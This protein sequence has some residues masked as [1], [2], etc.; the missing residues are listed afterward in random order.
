[1]KNKEMSRSELLEELG[2]LNKKIAELE[3]SEDKYRLISEKGSTLIATA[4]FTTKPVYTYVS[5]SYK[6]VLGSEPQDIVGKP[7]LDFL[8]HEDKERFTQLL[9]KYVDA[10]NTDTLPPDVT[11]TVE[12]RIRDT[13]ARGHWRHIESTVNIMH[14]ELLFISRD[15]TERKRAEELLKNAQAVL[16][17]RVE[18]RT[19]EL[20]E[21]N[22][23]L[24]KQIAERERIE[25]ELRESET[26]YRS[27]IDAMGDAIH[28]IDKDF[29]IVFFNN[30]FAEWTKD[31]NLDIVLD[32]N[33]IGKTIFELFHFLPNK[34]RGEYERVFT[35]GSVLV[36]EETTDVGNRIIITE[37]R[38]IPICENDKVLR[39]VT[40]IR[41]ITKQRQSK[42]ALEESEEK[43]RKLVEQLLSGTIIVQD[44]RIVFANEAMARISGYTV[45]E[46]LSLSPEQVKI[47][48]HPGDQ[49]LVWGRFKERLEGKPVPARYEYR[50]V[51]RDGTVIWLEMYAGLVTYNG[52]PAVQAA[53]VDISERKKAEQAVRESEELYHALVSA[54]PDA[55]IMTDMEGKFLYASPRALQLGGF[56]HESELINKSAFDFVSP[57]DRARAGD[58][59]R[60][61]L[62]NGRQESLEYT[63]LRKDGS[64]YVAEMSTAVIRD[65]DGQPRAFICTLRDVTERK[66]TE[67]ALRESEERFKTLTENVNV[68]IYR[69]TVG[70]KGEF[71]EANPAI[72]KMFGYG[73]KEEFLAVNVSDLYQQPDGRRSFNEKMLAF[74]FVRDEELQLRKKDGTPFFGSVSAVA[75]KD[76]RGGVKYY[77]G[78]IEDITDRKRAEEALKISYI[79]LRK[80]LNGT[81][82]ALASTA[83]KRDPYTAGHQQRVTQ[84]ACAI[85]LELGFSKAQIEGMHVAGS[86][87][88]IGKIHVA[89]EI[90]NK[91]RSLTE[92]EMELIRTH[93]EAGYEI[94]RSIDFPWPVA[95]IVFQHHERMDGS[96]YPRGITGDKILMEARILGVA[97]VV[98]AMVSHRP[99]RSALTLDDAIQEIMR[100]RGKLFDPEVTDACVQVFKKGF[101]F[102]QQ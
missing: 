16:E 13:F 38:K 50:V 31:L 39:I 93:S 99:Y 9:K 29:R 69:N 10:R 84:L 91:P 100:N 43:Y 44:F 23:L 90:L 81:V 102:Q 27:T 78:I 8:H 34:V 53:I 40:C 41:D 80:T 60:K 2:K 98:E 20:E 25:R 45:D 58:N 48:V 77:D 67:K 70:P 15:I 74:G 14:N 12:Y 61:T 86:V 4:T 79:K 18:E 83:E 85:A 1:M 3:K 96:G 55:V 75:V 87:H 35:T 51:R 19:T 26:R 37:T 28:V 17:K 64:S 95:E 66:Q 36:T 56:A 46:L 49:A 24:R 101:A 62:E 65:A 73:S 88:D 63:L 6:R 42:K 59:L 92:I 97:D 5:P 52:K 82:N 76:D 71:I 7:C 30:M 72:I 89:A 94:L 68:G 32:K 11:E 57:K 21:A 33:S 47:M 54:S 22:T